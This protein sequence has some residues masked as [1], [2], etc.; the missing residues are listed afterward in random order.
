[1]PEVVEL[2]IFEFVC[3]VL[4]VDESAVMLPKVASLV[5]Y[6]HSAT[7]SV[8]TERVTVDPVVEE[9]MLVTDGSVSFV[10]GR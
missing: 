9:L 4:F 6:L 3:V 5:E 7:S 1:M 8:V 10:S 2:Y